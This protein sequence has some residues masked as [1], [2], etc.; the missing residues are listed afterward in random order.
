MK[1]NQEM[2]GAT[3][4]GLPRRLM[5]ILYDSLVIAAV[6]I[7]AALPPVLITGGVM[8]NPALRLV[9][10]LY[11]AGVMF[12]FFGWFW[13]HGGQTVGMRAWRLRVE[14]Q[15]GQSIGWRTAFVRFVGAAPSAALLGMGYLWLLF[16]PQQR[17]WHDRLSGT[18]VVVLR[19]DPR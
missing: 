2:A 5:A 17:A 1:K 13:V 15:Q 4:A 18:R 6:L 14:G 10:Q 3:P 19:K 8:P 9:F 12:L 16:D 7:V 11:L